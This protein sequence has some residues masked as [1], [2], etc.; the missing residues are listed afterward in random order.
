MQ[1][2]TKTADADPDAVFPKKE[3]QHPDIPD[4]SQFSYIPHFPIHQHV[5]TRYFA[6]S[7][8]FVAGILTCL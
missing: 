6:G 5:T 3:L 2:L 8:I 7:C 4:I 1:T